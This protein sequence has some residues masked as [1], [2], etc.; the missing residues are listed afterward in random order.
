MQQKPLKETKSPEP[1]ALYR[2]LAQKG[3]NLN[4]VLITHEGKLCELEKGATQDTIDPKM[5]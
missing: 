5:K 4:V 1:E 3:R 2:H